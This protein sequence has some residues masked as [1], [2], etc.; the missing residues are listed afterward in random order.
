MRGL[1]YKSTGSWYSVKTLTNE[2]FDCRI[3]GKF[4]LDGIKST[5]PIAVG[6]Y[7][8]FELEKN[9]DVVTGVIN[10]ICERKNYVLRKSVNLSKQTHILASNIDVVF[11]I[12]T[13]SSPV[14]ST[15]FIDRFLL[16]SN[17]YSINTILLFNKI[18]L[19]D[20]AEKKILKKLIDIYTN[21][22]YECYEISAKNQYNIDKVQSLMK[23]KVSMFGGHSGVGKSTLINSLQPN[24]N[25]RTNNISVQHAQGQHTTTNAELYDLDFGAKII[26]TP[27]IRGFG[28]VD[29]NKSDIKN[30]FPEFYKLVN[31][32]KFND[33]MHVNE[34]KCIVKQSVDEGTIANSRY[35]NYLQILEDDKSSYRV[36]NFDV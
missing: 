22:G 30:Y 35:E 11:L 33:C 5:N 9:S 1:V 17:A 6:D 14:T 24:L 18:D 15:N 26:D 27:G 21:I 36:D 8:D 28:I 2:Q 32:C 7:V 10:N 3:K 13:I 4:R 20:E 23:D 31:Q 16:T 29:F 34:P 19:L 12:I 25:L